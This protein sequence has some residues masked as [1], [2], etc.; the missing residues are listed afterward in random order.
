LED[1][2]E[3]AERPG[4]GVEVEVER[5]ED[6]LVGQGRGEVFDAVDIAPKRRERGY[7]Q[8]RWSGERGWK[9]EAWRAHRW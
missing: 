2:Q 5:E 7:R 6:D 3:E 4:E 8:P 9:R 1:S